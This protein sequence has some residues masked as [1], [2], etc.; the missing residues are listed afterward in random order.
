MDK[1]RKSIVIMIE[2]GRKLTSIQF[3]GS[4]Y[5]ITKVSF[6]NTYI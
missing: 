3:L 1:E 6:E 4:M 2:N 5:Y